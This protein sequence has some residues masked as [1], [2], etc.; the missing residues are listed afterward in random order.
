M[1]KCPYCAED[2]QVAAIKCRHCGEFLDGSSRAAEEKFKWYF[3]TSFIVF[4]LCSVGPL[5][6]PLI[7][8]RPQTSR[9]WKIGLTMGI[10][11]LTWFLF[12]ATMESISTIM[13]Y[14]KLIEGQ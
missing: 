10:I 14:Y 2:I 13:E 9:A 4:A 3:R 7:W 11:V 12:Q 1:K 8:W 5:A 6:L